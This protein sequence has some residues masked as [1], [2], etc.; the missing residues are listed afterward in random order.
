MTITKQSPNLSIGNR[1]CMILLVLGCVLGAATAGEARQT[2]PEIARA[3][4]IGQVYASGN[5]YVAGFDEDE[6]RPWPSHLTLVPLQ[7]SPPRNLQAEFVRVVAQDS[8][9]QRQFARREGGGEAG[10]DIFSTLDGTAIQDRNLARYRAGM[11]V[12]SPESVFGWDPKLSFGEISYSEYGLPRPVSDRERREIDVEKRKVPAGTKCT[13]V[14][15]YIDSATQVLTAKLSR[16]LA[17][18]RLSRYETPGCAG[19][20]SEIYILDVIVPGQQ[21]RRFEFTHAKGVM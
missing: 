14:P 5:I 15:R 4:V 6:K 8:E 18:I 11:K 9:E 16:S 3:L 7:K 13:T 12:T 21:P 10:K 20:L 1:Q 19:H 2:P 17:N